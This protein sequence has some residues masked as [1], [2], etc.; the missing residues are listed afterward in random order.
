M[1]YAWGCLRRDARSAVM[2]Y[3]RGE[4]EDANERQRSRPRADHGSPQGQRA[5]AGAVALPRG[6]SPVVGHRRRPARTRFH[7]ADLRFSR[8]W[9]DPGAGS[10]LRCR[11]I[12]GAAGPAIGAR[13]D[14]SRPSGGISLG[15]LVAQHFA[16]T[17]PD[18]VDRLLLL[19]TTPRY[20][21]EMRQMWVERARQAREQGVASL[22]DSLLP[23]WFT[24][25]FISAEPPAVRYVRECFAGDSG[26]V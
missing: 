9:R 7:P 20:T 25:E 19:D 6:R 1:R 12:I 4:G 21:D 18:R 5:G 24:P 2:L 23:V 10:G 3:R 17:Y 26:E 13:G 11:P 22:L 16:A 8:P 15:G 14:R